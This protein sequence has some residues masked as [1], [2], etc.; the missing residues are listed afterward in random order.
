MPRQTPSACGTSRRNQPPQRRRLPH[1]ACLTAARPEA[2]LT[3]W[4]SNVPLQPPALGPAGSL[5]RPGAA[6]ALAP[7]GAPCL[8]INF[9]SIAALTALFVSFASGY[10]HVSGAAK[11]VHRRASSRVCE[12]RELGG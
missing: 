6:A 10:S 11:V 8:P 1:H 4:F 7:G 5:Q 9:R 12:G 2:A 3:V